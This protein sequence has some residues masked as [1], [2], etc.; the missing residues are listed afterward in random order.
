MQRVQY[1]G[2]TLYC[3]QLRGLHGA[4]RMLRMACAAR[5][6]MV[7]PWCGGVAMQQRTDAARA[8]WGQHIVLPSAMGATH[9]CCARMWWVQ[10]VETFLSHIHWF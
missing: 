5:Q 10:Y 9:A 3:H 2:G 1:G 8:I 7:T 6:C 4:T